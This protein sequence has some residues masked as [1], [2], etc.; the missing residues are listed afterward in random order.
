METTGRDA[1]RLRGGSALIATAVLMVMTACVP[2]PESTPPDTTGGTPDSAQDHTVTTPGPHPQN[3]PTLIAG[4]KYKVECSALQPEMVS[5][6]ELDPISPSYHEVTSARAVVGVHPEVLIAVRAGSCQQ[7]EGWVAARGPSTDFRAFLV[8]VCA[9]YVRTP[10]L[11]DECSINIG[12]LG[13]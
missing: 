5:D 6:E 2:S 12:T 7:E 8:A 11:D 13:R 3:A 4:H 1:K 9:A 10:E